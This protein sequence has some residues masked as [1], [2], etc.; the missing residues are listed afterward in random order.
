MTLMDQ[1]NVPRLRFPEFEGEWKRTKF[2]EIIEI[3]SG[4]VD[5]K[6]EPYSSMP[7]VAPDNI[8][9]GTGTLTNVRSAREDG[10]I[11]GKYAFD[12]NALVYS[13]IRP[14]LNKV[15]KPGYS[16]ICS[17]DMYPIWGKT[18]V[19]DADF[20]LQ[21]MLDERF[22]SATTAVSLRT[23][24]P[25]INRPDL[26]AIKASLPTLPEQHKIAGFLGAV[27]AKIAQLAEKKRL[28][29]DYKKGCMQQLFSQKI[30]FKD[31][32]GNDFPDWEEKRLGEGAE[33]IGGLTY[34]PSDVR[35]KGLLVLRSSN[36]QEGKIFLEDNVFVDLEVDADKITQPEDILLCV[37][38]GSQRLIGKS[39]LVAKAITNATHGAF[40]SVLRGEQ[41]RLLFQFMQTSFF[42]KEV[43]KNLGAT[44]N[45]IN[46]SDLKKFK[47][48]WPSHPDEQ[49]KI[50]DFLS[51]LDRKIDLVGQELTNAR[52][53]KQG[54]LQQMFV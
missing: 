25:K 44:I 8:G 18:D 38:N 39:A 47:L 49:R 42:F 32:T 51:A 30:C 24:L 35:E 33:L 40:M 37:R 31:D 53:F 13:K 16:G 29:E 41:N 43:Y 3:A 46:G 19:S 17:A 10:V 14:N 50:A 21:I 11:S 48:T 6:V 36:V 28:L 34:S 12:E 45:S 26:N 5:P 4:Q 9:G 7:H 20:L 23:G 52:T 15:A 1:Q 22:V 54:L 27:D 2:G